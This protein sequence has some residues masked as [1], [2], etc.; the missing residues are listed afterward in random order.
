MTKF[1]RTWFR[2]NALA[3]QWNFGLSANYSTGWIT[4]DVDFY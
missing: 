2:V 3:R 1:E 4:G